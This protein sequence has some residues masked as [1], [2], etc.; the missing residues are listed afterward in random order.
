[1]YELC[2]VQVRKYLLVDYGTEGTPKGI[3]AVKNQEAVI[4]PVAEIIEILLPA[5][6]RS[7]YWVVRVRGRVYNMVSQWWD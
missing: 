5:H 2:A 7:L 3:L 4:R 1:M 6:V